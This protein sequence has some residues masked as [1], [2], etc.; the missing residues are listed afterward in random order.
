M[1][2]D[3]EQADYGQN[4][5]GFAAPFESGFGDTSFGEG[6][7]VNPGAQLQRQSS[8][9]EGFI[10]RM[11][12]AAKDLLSAGKVPPPPPPPLS[13]RAFAAVR[14]GCLSDPSLAE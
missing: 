13:T 4:D 11:Q 12:A 6:C 9:T 3:V 5:A 14:T 2:Y 10:T 7:E 1:C 8:Q